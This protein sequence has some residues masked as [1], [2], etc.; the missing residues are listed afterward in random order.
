MRP[1]KP[2]HCPAAFSIPGGQQVSIL[3]WLCL[4]NKSCLEVARRQP[5]PV[6]PPTLEPDTAKS[7]PGFE[8]SASGCRL[9]RRLKLAGVTPRSQGV[10][11]VLGLREQEDG[12]GRVWKKVLP[13]HTPPPDVDECVRD[14]RLC[15]EGH[16][17]QNLPGSYRCLPDCAPGFQAAADGIG[18]EGDRAT[19]W[20][21][22]S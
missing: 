1:W 9:H 12:R 20:G 15:Q 2:S 13:Q 4:D 5:Q 19:G 6:P 18:C 14:A 7:P 16:Y 22:C 8:P 3:H 10:G 17:C 21:G 11:S